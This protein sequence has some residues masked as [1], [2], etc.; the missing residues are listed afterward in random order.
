MQN[1]DYTDFPF[2]HPWLSSLLNVQD[3]LLNL[4]Q[5]NIN[6]GALQQTLHLSDRGLL[7]W[8]IDGVASLLGR[9]VHLVECDNVK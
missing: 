8:N 5:N 6:H 2:S 3:S 7:L 4:T 9:K 1:G